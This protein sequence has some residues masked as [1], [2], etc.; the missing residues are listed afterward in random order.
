MTDLRSRSGD[1]PAPFLA[2][3]DH[4]ISQIEARHAWF[5]QLASDLGL[6]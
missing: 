5:R 6:A 1:L 4:D 3:L 2:W